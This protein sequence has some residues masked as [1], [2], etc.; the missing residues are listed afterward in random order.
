[1]ATELPLP[2]DW[3]LPSLRFA[4]DGVRVRQ[5]A[6]RAGALAVIR[7]Q[8]VYIHWKPGTRALVLHRL[9]SR[10]GQACPPFALVRT[11][12]DGKAYRYFLR[13][14][15]GAFDPHAHVHLLLFPDDVNLPCLPEIADS[16]SLARLLTPILPFEPVRICTSII[17]Y[18]PARRVVARCD[19]QGPRDE[20]AIVY[21]RGY[22][23][24][25]AAMIEDRW[26]E[27]VQVLAAAG[28]AAPSVLG[29]SGDILFTSHVPGRRPDAADA[30][31]IAGALQRVHKVG[32]RGLGQLRLETTLGQARY[33]ARLDPGSAKEV[34]EVA[35]IISECASTIQLPEGWTH[36]DFDPTQVLVERGHVAFLDLDKAGTDHIAKDVARFLAFLRTHDASASWRRG[37]LAGYRDI[38]EELSILEAA[39]LLD[40][41][42]T[43]FRILDPLWPRR[44]RAVIRSARRCLKT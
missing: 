33:L 5:L 6:R 2:D 19:V 41:S 13:T 8:P 17:H 35:L 31:T 21:A 10:R 1:M 22:A 12:N 11:D 4:V 24:G 25:E 28:V 44:L 23:E 40:L 38:R 16:A 42:V 18:K 3:L 36:R 15:R 9:T 26:C 34:A 32:T 29:R 20:R 30:V 14:G 37:F 7:A 27:G 43:P 39:A